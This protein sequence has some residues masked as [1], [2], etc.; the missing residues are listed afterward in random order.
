MGTNRVRRVVARLVVMAMLS[1]V[2]AAPLPASA[3]AS[4][5]GGPDQYSHY[6]V[7]DHT[8]FAVHVSTAA[9]SALLPNTTY[10]V[11]LRFT[12][13][14]TPAGTTNRGY[15]WNSRTGIWVQERDNLDNWSKFPTVTT[16]ASGAIPE[17]T[18]WFFGKFGDDTQ[19]GDYHLMVSLSAGVSDTSNSSFSP[20]VTVLPATAASWVHN[21]SD[22]GAP[23]SA[24]AR[25]TDTGASTNLAL[26]LTELQGVDDDS[27][28]TVD[29]EDLGTPGAIGDFRIG[30]PA[31][32]PLKVLLSGTPWLDSTL[33]SSGPADTDIALGAA[34]MAAPSAPSG[35]S[36][37]SDEGMATVSWGAA[38]DN[39]AV[40]GY[41]VYRWTP[42]TAGVTYAYSPV[43]ELIATLAASA[44]SY[45]DNGLVNGQTYLYEVRAFDAATNAG[46]RSN[47]A[48]ATPL[49]T[50]PHATVLPDVPDGA[51]GWYVTAPQVTLASG[52][53]GATTQYAFD[54]DAAVWTD[55]AG[56]IT[57][58][59]GLSTLYYRDVVGG[60]PGA[61]RELPFK[62]DTEAPQTRVSAPLYSVQVSSSTK[63]PV[64][65]DA[66]ETGSGI[67]GYDVDFS[68]SP[69]G[70]WTPAYSSTAATST[71]WSGSSGK[72]YYFRV[73]A[74]DVAG[75]ESTYVTSVG[76][77]V[78]YD[79]T[80]ASYGSYWKTVS[81]SSDFNGSYKY[82]TRSG[83]YAKFRLSR[84]TLYAVANTG[85]NKGKFAVYFR[86]KRIATISTYSTSSKTR[87]V[88]KLVKFS[89]S[90]PSDVKIVNLAT[91]GHPRVELDGFIVR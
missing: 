3:A 67:D 12:V 8:P 48:T 50:G 68:T 91:S 86:G 61:A 14:A 85:T 82:S 59:P 17:A 83:A 18:G 88:F 75:N 21:A 25:L 4:F 54:A 53:P 60:V 38:S 55:Y 74:R 13:S 90:S 23:S 43:H 49:S 7:N 15:T 66:T 30:V 52:L 19:S 63:F 56:T 78:P 39:T 70:P 58:A 31:G 73:L 81:R 16:D 29:D 24:I 28:G 27:N 44:R 47:T 40:A 1:S 9:S 62:V 72:T 42:L 20:T 37:T 2:I 87:R 71:T 80:K 51:N 5:N 65:W 89:G 69:S 34:D 57:V 41:R 84:G 77:S 26:Q 32:T 22:T 46:P 6:Y 33:L 35:L 10:R 45:T 64:S 36:A 11:K 76:T 79:Q